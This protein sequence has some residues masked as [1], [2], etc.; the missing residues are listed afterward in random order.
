MAYLVRV[1]VRVRSYLVTVTV[2][3]EIAHQAF[4]ASLVLSWLR[5]R[6][7]GLPG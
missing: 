1:R 6:R 5:P 3:R 2:R 7:L 4:T